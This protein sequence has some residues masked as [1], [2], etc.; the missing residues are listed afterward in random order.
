MS[1]PV[2]DEQRMR[3]LHW[4]GS[5]L[6]FLQC[7]HIWLKEGQPVTL[8]PKRSLPEQVKEGKPRQIN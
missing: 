6:C 5:V 8:I 7:W 2:V 3:P 1:S 4:L